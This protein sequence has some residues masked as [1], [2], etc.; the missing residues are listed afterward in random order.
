MRLLLTLPWF[1]GSPPGTFTEPTLSMRAANVDF[2]TLGEKVVVAFGLEFLD[3]YFLL[4]CLNGFEWLLA[5]R[6]V[7]KLRL[8]CSCSRFPF[9][10]IDCCLISLY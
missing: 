10:S 6:A 3:Y 8:P 9:K 4:T 5:T 7:E 2:L 1:H